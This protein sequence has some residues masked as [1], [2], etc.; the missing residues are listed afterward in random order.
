MEVSL[1]ALYIRT[2]RTYICPCTCAVCLCVFMYM[3]SAKLPVCECN[4]IVQWKL[5][6]K[7]TLTVNFCYSE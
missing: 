4:N 3:D 6:I 5:F 7:N 1:Y 2:V